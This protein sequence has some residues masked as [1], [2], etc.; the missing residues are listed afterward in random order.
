[1]TIKIDQFLPRVTEAIVV[2][3]EKQHDE[4]GVA[5]T[6]STGDEEVRFIGS[7]IAGQREAE[8]LLAGKQS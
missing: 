1:M 3:I 7:K 5:I 2:P 8:R 4:W 6:W